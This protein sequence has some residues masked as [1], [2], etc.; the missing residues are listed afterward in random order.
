MTPDFEFDDS[1]GQYRYLTGPRRGQFVPRQSIRSAL[2]DYIEDRQRYAVEVSERFRNNQIS[3]AEWQAEM[4][5]TAVRIHVASAA[6]A[7]GGWAQMTQ[8]DYGRVGQIW[9]QELGGRPGFHNGLRGMIEQMNNGLPL[10]GRWMNR[11][12]QYMQAGRTT[13][14]VVETL[15]MERR[16]FDEER[17]IR[18]SRDSCDECI[19]QETLG[20]QPIAARVIKQPGDRQCLRNC[21]CTKE[22]RRSGSASDG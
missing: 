16:G 11:V 22:Y 2:D 5:A 21:K 12:Q 3:F 15:E 8:S 13:Y 10:D 9:R 18:H 14:H 19:D 4:E 17:S 7:K 1:T 20:W 6:S